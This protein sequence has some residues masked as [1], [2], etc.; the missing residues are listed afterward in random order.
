MASPQM[1]W[2]LSKDFFK[3]NNPVEVIAGAFING[4][5][6]LLTFNSKMKLLRYKF[7]LARQQLQVLEDN[8]SQDSPYN[9]RGYKIDKNY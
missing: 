1:I 2:Q 3:R 7:M 5:N 8:I 4:F 6:D 9:I